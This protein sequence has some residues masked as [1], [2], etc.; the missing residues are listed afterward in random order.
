M[1]LMIEI[2][3]WL[4]VLLMA[5]ETCRDYYYSKINVLGRP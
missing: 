5:V 4:L 1:L 3:D 2:D